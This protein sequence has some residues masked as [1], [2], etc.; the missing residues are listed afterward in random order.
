DQRTFVSSIGIDLNK[1]DGMNRFIVTYE[2]PNI[3]AIG[4]DASEDEKTFVV[5]T[6][7]SSIFQ[8]GREFTTTVPFPF[9]YKHLKVL[10]LG[11]DLMNEGKLV[12]EIVDELN[13]DTKINKKIQILVAEGKAGEI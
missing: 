11:E 12:R 7:A 8:A 5:S 6:P 13:R 10:V 3:N 9:Y 4:K 2:Y 1:E